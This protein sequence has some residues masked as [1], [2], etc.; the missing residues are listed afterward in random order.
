MASTNDLEFMPW[1]QTPGTRGWSEGDFVSVDGAH[2]G[3]V[4]IENVAEVLYYGTTGRD[5]DGT[6]AAVMRL[7]DGRFVAYE[8][9]W[10]PTGSGFSYDAYGGDSNLCFANDLNALILSALT[11]AGRRL[12]GIPAEGLDG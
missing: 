11:D 12:C 2:V 1:G 6:E 5:W 10:G 7:Q 9:W 4:E 3:P 8:T